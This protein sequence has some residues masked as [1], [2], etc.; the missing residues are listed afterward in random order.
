MIKSVKSNKIISLLLII[1]CIIILF[2]PQIYLKSCLNAISVWAF[3]VLPLMFPF[4]VFTRI[5]VNLS[6]QKTSVMDKF[7][8]K[9]YHTPNGSFSTFFLSTLSGYPMGAKLICTMYENKQINSSDARKMLSFCSVSGPI[10][11]LGTVGVAM[12]NSFTSGL[13]ILISNIL[14]SLV[15]G[16]IY[17]G[18]NEETNSFIPITKKNS[19]ILSESV[20][21]SL[22][23]ILLVGA[24]IVL[25]FLVIDILHNLKITDAL[26]DLICCVF[27]LNNKQNVVQSVL[28][29]C[30]EITHGILDLSQTSL[31]LKVKTVISS[32]LIGFGGISVM[33]QSLNFL[34]TLNLPIKT[35]FRQKLTQSILCLLIA[36][37]IAI[38]I[39]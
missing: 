1:M 31:S 14:A 33:M 5:I 19:N 24:Y 30:I 39:L 26:T 12:L 37:I 25:S 16:L 32:G 11:M 21:D 2:N 20:Y 35:L 28:N 17:R 29:G 15:N 22:I 7:F 23:S 27:N 10:F 8:N 3:K 4:F 9:L 38:I 18:K 36:S 34:S 6:E 13:I